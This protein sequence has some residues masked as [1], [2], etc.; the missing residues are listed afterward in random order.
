[1]KNKILIRKAKIEELSRIN[2]VTNIAYKTPF[3]KNGIVTKAHKSKDLK[4]DFL[5]KKVGIIVAIS[6]GKIVGVQKY[7]ELDNKK[8]YIFQLAVL[9]TYRGKGIGSQL[10]KETEKIAKE[11]KLKMITL[12][13]MKEKHLPEYYEKLGYKIDEVKKQKDYHMVYMSKT[14]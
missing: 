11:K 6:S 7:K 2:Y 10:L 1:M 3:V 13:C 9:K 12:D 4:D 14:I 5:S 8:L